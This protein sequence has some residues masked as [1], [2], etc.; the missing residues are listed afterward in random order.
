MLQQHHIVELQWTPYWTRCHHSFCRCRLFWMFMPHVPATTALR[1]PGSSPRHY[2][3][4][5]F[6]FSSHIKVSNDSTTSFSSKIATLGITS[7]YIFLES[8]RICKRYF[9]SLNQ[10]YE[11]SINF[12]SIFHKSR[13]SK[14]PQTQFKSQ[15]SKLCSA[16]SLPESFAGYVTLLPWFRQCKYL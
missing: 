9:I 10:C 8:S 1:K 12:S 4:L 7:R 13:A 2:N 16:I 11:C 14:A 5:V 6:Y 3:F 15:H